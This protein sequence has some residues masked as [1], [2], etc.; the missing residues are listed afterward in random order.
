MQRDQFCLLNFWLYILSFI[1]RTFCFHVSDHTFSLLRY[2]AP[3]FVFLN[4]RISSFRSEF[5][6]WTQLRSIPPT[7][8]RQLFLPTVILYPGS[9]YTQY[10][11]VKGYVF[12]SNSLGIFPNAGA[13]LFPIKCLHSPPP[14]ILCSHGPLAIAM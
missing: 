1:N 2:F 12:V 3:T 8:T 13:H 7:P 6:I 4:I 11:D 14:T 9:L 10:V 5:T